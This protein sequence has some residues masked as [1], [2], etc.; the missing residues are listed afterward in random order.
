MRDADH[1]MGP[2]EPGQ[3]PADL[4]RGPPADARVH[5]VEDH[6]RRRVRG[7]QHNL[8]GEHDP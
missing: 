7:G 3:A 2:G 1:L 6:G 5:L 4:D 8:D